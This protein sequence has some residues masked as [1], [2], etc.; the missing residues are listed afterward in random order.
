ML[1]DMQSAESASQVGNLLDR[2]LISLDDD[3][4]DDEWARGLFTDD[5]RVAFPMSRHEGVD[6]L[7]EYHRG[8]LAAFERTQHLNSPAVVEPRGADEVRLRANV[9]STHVRLDDGALFTA[10]TLVT[11]AARR[12]GEGWRLSALSFRVIWTTGTPPAAEA[13]R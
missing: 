7:A 12:T 5:A 10:G 13:A 4:L 3:K 6:G 1:P 8:A 9:I 2:Y 11:G